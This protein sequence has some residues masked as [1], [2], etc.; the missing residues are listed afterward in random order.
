MIELRNG[1]LFESILYNIKKTMKI[2]HVWGVGMVQQ[3]AMKQGRN[4]YGISSCDACSKICPYNIEGVW[5]YLGD[6]P[7][8]C[9]LV[10]P[11]F[12]HMMQ[13]LQI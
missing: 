5:S 12:Y 11:V 1:W 6:M 4:V 10:E 9:M 3:K 13:A 8:F 2:L 7:T